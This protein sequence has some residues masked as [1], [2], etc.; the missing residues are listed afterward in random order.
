[1]YAAALG[2]GRSLERLIVAWGLEVILRH[3]TRCTMCS[4]VSEA[5]MTAKDFREYAEEHLGW[6]KD[7][8]VNQGAPNVSPDG[9]G[10]AG[11]R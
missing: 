6:A 7:S 9:S 1:M 5:R 3:Y 8:K 2:T 10:L 4:Y 11:S